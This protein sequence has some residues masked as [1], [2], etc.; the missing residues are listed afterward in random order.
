[1]KKLILAIALVAMMA[2]GVS[3]FAQGRYGADSAE[4]VKYLS[5]YKDYFKQKNY[6]EAMP[7][8][9][10]AYE[11]CPPS[12]MQTML[13]DGT[14]LVR[15][16]IAKNGK[17][18][19]YQKALIDS[20]FTLHDQRAEFFPKYAVITRNNK[21]LD[22]NNYLRNDI[23]RQ[24]GIYEEVI[25]AN[26]KNT[27]TTIFLFDLNIAIDLYQA[28]KLTAEDVI[29]TY[30]RNLEYLDNVQAKTEAEATQNAK[31]KTDLESLFITSKVAS[32][33]NLLALF[34]PRYEAT[35]ND[36]ELCTG[37]V[38]MMNSTEGCQDNELYLKAATSM[39]KLNP[40]AS[41]AHALFLLNAAKGNV[42]EAISYA[43]ESIASAES[44]AVTDAEYSVE[45]A[46]FCLKNG[47]NVK[48][49]DV[50]KQAVELDPSNAGKAY[51]VIA[52][53]WGSVSCGGNEIEK[54][55]P[56]WVAVDYLQ[57][58]K[59]ADET[60]AEEAN[61]LIGQYSRYYPQTAEAFMYDIT[62]GQQYTVSC[63]GL[64]AV[65]VVRTQK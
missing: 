37:I 24:Y 5:Y 62:D 57:K 61:K 31:V 47:K 20:L 21:A 52:S 2:S 35:P 18:P 25:A 30:Q 22:A 10:K 36:L 28:G 40:S 49:F 3:A 44:D 64:R 11:L 4:C 58:A 38:K 55:A 34:T 56:Y 48:A 53:V 65:T 46:A 45:L 17:N 8:W 1:M 15:H 9:R 51:M 32:C 29:K 39:Y 6:A 16:F 23:E 41:A 27:K 59:A 13:V 19:E 43:E 54:R 12:S 63:G 60:L 50:A 42:E 14:Q 26:G 33:E 7:L